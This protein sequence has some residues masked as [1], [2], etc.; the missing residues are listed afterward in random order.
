MD[1]EAGAGPSVDAARWRSSV[2][3][4]GIIAGIVAA[5][6]GVISLITVSVGCVAGGILQL[7]FGIFVLL[8]EG[9]FLCYLSPSIQG[10]ADNIDARPLFI[11]GLVYILLGVLPMIFCNGFLV[12]IGS[13]L[14]LLTGV[15]Y[16]V[17]QF[18]NK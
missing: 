18:L 10:L 3:V 4:F 6:L 13:L 14:I 17:L 5:I 11:K 15:L 1:V 7:F 8:V 9:P 2:K 12:I 16:V